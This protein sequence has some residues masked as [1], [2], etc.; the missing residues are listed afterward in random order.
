MADIHILAGDGN[1]VWTVVFHFDVPNAVNDVLVNYRTALVNSGLASTSVLP[2]GD[3]MAGTID[4]AE[5]VKLAAGEVY[6][7]S[8][9][10]AADTPGQTTASLRTAICTQY[11]TVN[12]AVINRLRRRLKYFGHTETRA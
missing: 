3:G 5:K 9:T 2:D 8:D 1:A 10:F 4:A 12:D 6:E 7:H 11:A